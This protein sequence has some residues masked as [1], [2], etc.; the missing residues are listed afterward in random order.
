MELPAK[1]A[2]VRRATRLLAAYNRRLIGLLSMVDGSLNSLSKLRMKHYRWDPVY[3]RAIGRQTTPIFSRW[4]WDYGPLSWMWMRW[5]TDGKDTPNRKQS[6]MVAVQHMVDTGY[7]RGEGEPSPNDFAD[8]DET[9]T[10]LWVWVIAVAG[11]TSDT[12]DVIRNHIDETL[13]EEK[14]F[15]N[16]MH[17]VGTD[18]LE[19][20]PAGTELRYIGWKIDISALATEADVE[21]EVLAPLRQALTDIFK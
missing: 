3:H 2:N 17:Q 11:K 5:T 4:G 12:W 14:H 1:L 6:T 9:R 15:D 21:R 18:E 13:G 10:E 20:T 19:G 7:T 16:V 8:A